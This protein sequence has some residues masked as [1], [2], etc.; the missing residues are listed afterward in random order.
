MEIGTDI[1]FLYSFFDC[2]TAHL[3]KRPAATTTR[4]SASAR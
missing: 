1:F 4:A 2:H 3:K